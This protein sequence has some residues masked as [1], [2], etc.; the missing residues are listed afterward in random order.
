MGRFERQAMADIATN[1]DLTQRLRKEG[2]CFNFFQALQLLE[3]KLLK[4]KGIKNPLDSGA[5]RCVPDSSLTFP[6]S[7]VKRIEE[8]PQGVFELTLTFMG[9]V[10]V[11]SPLP[12]YFSEYLARHEDNSQPLIDFL[13]IFNHR[14]YS[15]FYRAWKK[16]RFI[17]Y[18]FR[19]PTPLSRRIAML[20]GLDP[21]RLS[22]PAYARLLSYTGIFTG[23]CRGKNAMISLL[24]D[25][26]ADLP[27]DV[28]EYQPRWVEIRNPVKMGVDVR[29]G[30]NSIAGTYSWDVSG[31]FRVAVGPLPRE[32]FEQFLPN[33]EN[34][35]K[36]KE[37]ISVFLAEPLAY[38]IEVKLQSSELVPVV[39][40]ANNTRLGETSSLGESSLHS[41][42][43]SIV[44]E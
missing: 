27:V 3:E 15:L 6:P 12:L 31:K 34:I 29:L 44:I 37:L 39:L 23:K 26:F 38:D 22:D 19:E 14:C 18:S 21:L 36:M 41:D 7:D 33:S 30:V 13:N 17:S 4:E 24:S 8:T 11:S 1:P 2:H 16:Y 9:L 28:K 35:K 43:K 25:F 40:A 5:I 42:I 20:A 32:R 10:G